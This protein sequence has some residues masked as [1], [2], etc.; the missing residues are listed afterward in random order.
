MNTVKKSFIYR[1]LRTKTWSRKESNGRVSDRPLEAI[2]YQPKMIVSA[3]GRERVR[4]SRKK[5]V[6]A[7]IKGIVAAV[8][9]VETFDATKRS[10]LLNLGFR[11]ITYNPYLYDT[12]VF[13]DTKEPVYSASIAYMFANMKVYVL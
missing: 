13:E 10:I 7:G 9:K 3:P 1:N 11:E 5:V 6:H 2:I 4:R 12:F 8:S